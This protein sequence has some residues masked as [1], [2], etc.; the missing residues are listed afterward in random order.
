MQIHG[1]GKNLKAHF[2][3]SPSAKQSRAADGASK[4]SEVART[5]ASNA[6]SLFDQVKSGD[7]LRKQLLVEIKAKVDAGEYQTRAA[8]VEA[9]EQIVGY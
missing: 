5:S 6:K 8:A 9:A 2:Q 1:H 7:A 3:S 4:G